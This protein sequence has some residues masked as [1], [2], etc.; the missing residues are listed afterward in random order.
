MSVSHKRRPRQVLT[1]RYAIHRVVIKLGSQ[2]ELARRLGMKTTQTST[3]RWWLRRGYVP[4]KWVHRVAAIGEIT[5]MELVAD[6]PN[7]QAKKRGM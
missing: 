3:I 5:V 1:T 2:A 7:D 4:A 6:W